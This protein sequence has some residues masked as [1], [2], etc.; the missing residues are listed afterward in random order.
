MSYQTDAMK[1]YADF[2]TAA[3]ENARTMQ[4]SYIKA[5]ES[6][7]ESVKSPADWG[8]SEQTISS[9]L[10]GMSEDRMREV[11]HQMANA[12][13]RGWEQA[14]NMLQAT[15]EWMRWPHKAPG[16]MM[17]EWFD[18]LNRAAETS[19]APAQAAPMAEPVKGT[20][21]DLTAIKGI[22][23]K[24]AAALN[25]LGVTHY[26][27]IAEWS[28]ADADRISEQVGFAG[29]ATRDKWRMQAKKLA[30]AGA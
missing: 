21:D 29:R 11:F 22:G 6:M 7:A 24:L 5:L 3:L 14:A 10:P 28:K 30:K 9:F 23:K 12:N 4:D 19:E 8:P 17:T 2:M 27:D 26:A 1:T 15:P 13:L 25:D 20:P 16:S 18:Q